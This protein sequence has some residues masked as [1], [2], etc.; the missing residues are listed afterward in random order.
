MRN[1]SS[2][3]DLQKWISAEYPGQRVLV[4]P[5]AYPVQVQ[6]GAL[7]LASVQT[8]L[9]MLANADFLC[10]ELAISAETDIQTAWG[11]ASLQITDSASQENWWW[12]PAKVSK[13][14]S[15]ANV[16]AGSLNRQF[17]GPCMTLP[18]KVSA[19][20]S[21]TITFTNDWPVTFTL[22]TWL[23]LIGVNIYP[24]S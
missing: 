17:E 4:K 6:N 14:C 21:L 9:R 12:N 8:Q 18:R 20:A 10:T 5:F 2:M 13:V 15:N 1:V 7:T 11:W 19:N 23:T 3:V 22:E 24:L 16:G